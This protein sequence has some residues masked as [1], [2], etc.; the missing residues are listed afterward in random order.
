MPEWME[1]YRDLIGNTGGNTIEE[2]MNDRSTTAQVN[3]IRAGLIVAVTSQVTLLYQL[4]RDGLLDG[5]GLPEDRAEIIANPKGTAGMIPSGSYCARCDVFIGYGAI[6]VAKP[7]AGKTHEWLS[8]HCW[9]CHRSRA[10]I[11][12]N[13]KGRPA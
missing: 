12:A 7:P 4:H 13:P 3:V 1:R 6:G 9:I 10:E 5:D 11:I 8:Q 2:L